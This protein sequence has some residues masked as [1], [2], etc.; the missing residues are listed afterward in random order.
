MSKDTLELHD[1]EV[2]ERAR[3]PLVEH[4]PLTAEGYKGIKDRAG[5]GNEHLPGACIGWRHDQ[6]IGQEF[7]LD[8]VFD[9]GQRPGYRGAHVRIVLRLHANGKGIVARCGRGCRGDEEYQVGHVEEIRSQVQAMDCLIVSLQLVRPAG[10]RVA[11][12]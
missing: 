9:H 1:W 10:R 8:A 7:D 5:I 3:E 12:G 11:A 4:L 2:L 6:A